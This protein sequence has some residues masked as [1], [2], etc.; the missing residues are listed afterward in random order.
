MHQMSLDT[1]VIFRESMALCDMWPIPLDHITHF[2]AYLSLRIS[3][4]IVC[5]FYMFGLKLY[6]ISHCIQ[7]YG[8]NKW[9][10][11]FRFWSPLINNINELILSFTS[12]QHNTMSGNLSFNNNYIRLNKKFICVSYK[13]KIYQD[14]KIKD[15]DKR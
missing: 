3:Y 13:D 14:V 4:L 12:A 5:T 8:S 10:Y 11:P 2:I 15:K 7:N 1:F 6:I 9:H